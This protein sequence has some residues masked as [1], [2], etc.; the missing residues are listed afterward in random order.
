M[1][2]GCEHV[3]GAHLLNAEPHCRKCRPP[4]EACRPHGSGRTILGRSS[5]FTKGARVTEEWRD[6][7]GCE[8]FYEISDLGNVRRKE[9]RRQLK[10]SVDWKGYL[11]VGLSVGGKQKNKKIHRMLAEAFIPNPEGFPLVRHLDDVKQNNSLDNL[12]WGTVSQNAYD[13]VANGRNYWKS[14]K[15]CENGHELVGDNERITA[16]GKRMC[17]QCWRAQMRKTKAA[18]RKKGLPPGHP[19]HGTN[20]GYM[21]WGCRCAECVEARAV[22]KNNWRLKRKAR[23]GY[24]S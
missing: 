22:Y 7:V 6:V 11:K 23:L 13:A 2:G 20:S 1:A 15:F 10:Q 24:Y 21:S 17:R 4:L 8:G 3:C 18:Q 19:Q 5:C 9:T 14:R 16:R 12:A